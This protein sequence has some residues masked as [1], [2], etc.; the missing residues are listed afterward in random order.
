M[1]K[2]ISWY[3]PPLP[4]TQ[5]YGIA[6]VETIKALQAKGVNVSYNMDEPFVYINFIQ[7]EYYK[8]NAYQYK[9]GYT[10]WESTEIPEFWPTYMKA[11]QEVWTTSSFCADI[12][13]ANNVN[14]TI[15]VVPHGIDPEIFRIVD[16]TLADR[17]IFLHIGGPIE[18]KGGSL[19]A[20]AF[21]ETFDDRDDVFLVMKSHGP[22]EARWRT[23]DGH[24][25]GNIG[26]HPKI[27]VF[28]GDMDHSEIQKLYELAHCC[29]YPSLCEGFGM[30]PFQAIATGLPTITTNL[31]GMADFAEMSMALDAK[32]GPG[33]GI[34][35]GEIAVPDYDHLCELML[36]AVDNWEEE[37]KKAMKSA[38]IIH[39]TQTW[40]H[41]ADLI[42][43]ILG[44]KV[45]MVSND[46]R[47]NSL[48]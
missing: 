9:I 38:R 40:A 20:K 35:I 26:N 6:A 44:N 34:H 16:R 2:H 7:P 31:T 12:Y 30:I 47:S 39:D 41:I 27:Q 48:H 42:M 43:D 21:I 22:S 19:V 23:K 17:F 24:Y 46:N 37:K 29:V 33:Y 25:M 3:T 36:H 18:R 8:G 15:R 11:M 32:W 10:P 5:G 4:Q 13:K 1:R 45:E 28:E 14:D